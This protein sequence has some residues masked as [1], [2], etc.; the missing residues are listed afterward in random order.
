MMIVRL[1]FLAGAFLLAEAEPLLQLQFL[2]A[3]AAVECAA[4]LPT[5]R[6]LGPRACR[7]TRL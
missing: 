5:V 1:F 4:R 2:A 7:R 6:R 3:A